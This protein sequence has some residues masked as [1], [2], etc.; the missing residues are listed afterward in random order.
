MYSSK[1]RSLIRCENDVQFTNN[2]IG[3]M[4]DILTKSIPKPYKDVLSLIICFVM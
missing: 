2:Y 1:T 3:E 4:E